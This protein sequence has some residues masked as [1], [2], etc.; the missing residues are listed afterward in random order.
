MQQAVHA[1][2]VDE[3]A[4][5]GEAADG[6]AHGFTFADLGVAALLHAALFFFGEGAPV[7]HYIFLGGIELDDAAA[8]FLPNQLLH[9]SGVAY[10]AAR[11]R[12]ESAHAYIHAEAA[13]DDAGDCAHDRRFLGEGLLQ[14]RPV[15]GLRNFLAGKLVV[16]LRIA[17]LD[18]HRHL[19]AG[20]DALA[21]ALEHGQR[22]DAFGLETNIKED[23]LAG[24]GNHR[25]FKLL[26]AVFLLAG[27][28]LLV[29]GE[30]V[31]ERLA[32][33]G[34]GIG[35]WKVWIRHER[36]TDSRCGEYQLG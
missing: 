13:L 31:F 14:R 19:V 8:N 5:V 27:V 3:R 34:D 22:H 7:N 32:G 21:R 30:N 33:F 17:T 12:H 10:S 9:F 20:F 4:V 29:L 18:R 1:A 28:A 26:A 2:Q 6:A 35:L 24:N 15:R 11:G 36:S 16:A 25:G 23:G